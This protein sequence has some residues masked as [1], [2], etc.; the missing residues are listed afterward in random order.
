MSKE[1]P[2]Y[3]NHSK[4]KKFP[5][6]LYHR[7][8]EKSLINFLQKNSCQSQK[9]S[10]LI[11]GPGAL[12]EHPQ[13]VQLN[14]D[15]HIA[16]IDQRVI[17][18]LTSKHQSLTGH[19]VTESCDSY[20]HQNFDL[21]YAKEVIEHFNKPR[22]FTDKIYDLLAPKGHFWISTPNYGFFLLPFLEK[23]ILELIARMSGFSRKDIH[24]SKFEYKALQRILMDSGFMNIKVEETRFKLALI[25]SGE[26][27]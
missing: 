18:H 20:P 10:L 1:E 3:V 8:L 25:A 4:T 7:P 9:K 14:F 22:L 26:K 15:I 16:D 13:L 5:W 24:P 11:I 2:Y 17:D 19:L 27:A 12:E 6:S 21:I 23:T